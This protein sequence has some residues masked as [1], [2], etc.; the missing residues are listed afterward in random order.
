MFHKIYRIMPCNLSH[1]R[2]FCC[3]KKEAVPYPSLDPQLFYCIKDLFHGNLHLIPEDSH[4]H[5]VVRPVYCRS[6]CL[7]SF[8]RLQRIRRSGWSIV[9]SSQS[10]WTSTGDGNTIHFPRLPWPQF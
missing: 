8:E 1:I 2:L 5:L 3:Q 6:C 10:I 9:L 7:I 4:R